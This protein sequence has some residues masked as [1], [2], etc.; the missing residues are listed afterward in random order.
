[1]VADLV[2][3]ERCV[4]YSDITTYIVIAFSS[5]RHVANGVRQMVR[6]IVR[7]RAGRCRDVALS[8]SLYIYE[9]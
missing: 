6:C 9:G 3:F 1:M 5:C 7:C 2:H 4:V 8:P